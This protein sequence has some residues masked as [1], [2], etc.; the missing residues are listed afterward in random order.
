MGCGGRAHGWVVSVFV[1]RSNRDEG[2]APGTVVAL[3]K[4][5]MARRGSRP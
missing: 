4:R 2:L 3:L 1:D 5:D